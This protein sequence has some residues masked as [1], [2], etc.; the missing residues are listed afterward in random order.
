[1]VGLRAQRPTQIVA[2]FDLSKTPHR[3]IDSALP[4]AGANQMHAKMKIQ[5]ELNLIQSE[6][7]RTLYW[8]Y[9][10]GFKLHNEP[11]NQLTDASV[12]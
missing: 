1:M 11:Q 9:R 7:S 6:P 3:H 10:N 5:P 2:T 8:I 12:A 4:L